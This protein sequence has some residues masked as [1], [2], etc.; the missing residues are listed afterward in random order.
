ML[1]GAQDLGTGNGGDPEPLHCPVLQEWKQIHAHHVGM[2]SAPSDYKNMHS[3]LPI[4]I[5]L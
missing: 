5:F 1:P 4:P 2:A 3:T